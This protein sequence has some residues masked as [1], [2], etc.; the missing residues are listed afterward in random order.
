MPVGSIATIEEAIEF[1][2][3]G[4]NPNPFLDE[5]VVPLHLSTAERQ[6]LAALSGSVRD[7]TP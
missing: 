2:D 1:Y 3:R 4:G 6:A 5:N 7:G